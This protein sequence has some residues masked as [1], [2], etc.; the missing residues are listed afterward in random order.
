MS[1]GVVIGGLRYEEGSLLKLLGPREGRIAF[2]DNVGVG[3]RRLLDCRL[4]G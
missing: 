3:N 1:D 4:D 2:R